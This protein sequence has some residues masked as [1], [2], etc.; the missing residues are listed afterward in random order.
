MNVNSFFNQIHAYHR[1]GPT[2]F[3]PAAWGD[4]MAVKVVS[5]RPGNAALGLPTVPATIMLFQAE[6]GIML[7]TLDGTV[8]TAVRTAAGSGSWPYVVLLRSPVL[9]PSIVNTI[10][11]G[12]VCCLCCHSVSYATLFGD[13]LF[14]RTFLDGVWCWITG[15][16][17]HL[18]ITLCLPQD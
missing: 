9:I 2:L 3:K 7:A 12:F 5:V 16:M 15:T 13:S 1:W 18:S 6:T 8:L 11:V 17:A 4:Y 14:S 10:S